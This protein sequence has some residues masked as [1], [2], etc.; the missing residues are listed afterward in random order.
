M[1]NEKILLKLKEIESE[2]TYNYNLEMLIEAI[3]NDILTEEAKRTGRNDKKKSAERI[4]KSAK[5]SS[6]KE[7]LQYA[8]IKDD[9]QYIMDGYRLATFNE[10]YYIPLP[11]A[12]AKAVEMYPFH[13][14]SCLDSEMD[15][16]VL[17][18]PSV[19]E[20]KGYIKIN[21][22]QKKE[23]K[24]IFFDFGE[25]LPVVNAEYLLDMIILYPDAK[26]TTKKVTRNCINYNIIHF[27]D[28]Q[29]NK[30]ALMPVKPPQSWCYVEKE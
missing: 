10:K 23:Y 26:V 19:A 14:L 5:K 17:T 15:D 11:E 16:A 12:P 1:N 7:Y 8:C 6:S 25:G 13:I 2:I 18:L 28:T 21:Q 20:L 9:V 4:L 27:N 30:G 3:K 22:Y 29:G 24:N